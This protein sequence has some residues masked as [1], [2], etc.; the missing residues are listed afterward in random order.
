MKS[1]SEEVILYLNKLESIYRNKNYNFKIGKVENDKYYSFRCPSVSLI[2]SWLSLE[3]GRY[4]LMLEG[5]SIKLKPKELNIEYKKNK[6]CKNLI[7][8][9]KILAKVFN[10]KYSNI[11]AIVYLNFKDEVPEEEK[12]ILRKYFYEM[13]KVKQ[14]DGSF[15]PYRTKL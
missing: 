15:V 6:L 2:T 11:P 8:K 4:L 10:I 5:K 12:M 13:I 9:D 3:Y 7:E 1:I 14:W